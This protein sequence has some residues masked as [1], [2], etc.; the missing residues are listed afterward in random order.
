[1]I[2]F[3]LNSACTKC[4]IKIKKRKKKRHARLWLRIS[5]FIRRRRKDLPLLE[6]L[7]RALFLL[8]WYFILYFCSLKSQQLHKIMYINLVIS[9]VKRGYSDFFLPLLDRQTVTSSWFDLCLLFMCDS[10]THNL[11]VCNRDVKFE[12]DKPPS[13]HLYA[14]VAPDRFV[15]SPRPLHRSGR[16]NITR[17]FVRNLSCC[18]LCRCRTAAAFISGQCSLSV[19]VCVCVW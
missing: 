1:M 16:S 7:C 2:S 9:K 10:T 8:F 3:F 4:V 6:L 5:R 17:F 15:N 14:S 18:S 11:S 19:T 12:V 13:C